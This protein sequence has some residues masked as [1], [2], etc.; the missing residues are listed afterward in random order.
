MVAMEFLAQRCLLLFFSTISALVV[1]GK[2]NVVSD[3]DIVYE[4]RPRLERFACSDEC[5][6][7]VN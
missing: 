5:I 3:L 2:V 6:N 4:C 1:A 7:Y